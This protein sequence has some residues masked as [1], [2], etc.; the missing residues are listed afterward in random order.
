MET[1]QSQAPQEPN[2]YEFKEPDTRITYSTTSKT[3]A[4]L[5]TYEHKGERRS[6]QGTEIRAQSTEIGRLVTVTL[7]TVPDLHTVTL[8]VLVPPANLN[9]NGKKTLLSTEAIRTTMRTSIAGPRLVK[10]QIADYEVLR[11]HGEARS[12]VS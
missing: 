12:V 4:P 2:I 5:L 10:G 9:G 8:T 11:L 1:K 7:E 6:F 3:G